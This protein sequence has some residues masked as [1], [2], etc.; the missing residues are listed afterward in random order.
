[1]AKTQS[2]S[3]SSDAQQTESE[4]YLSDVLV[5]IPAYEEE[6]SIG[7]V[8]VAAKNIA[9][10]VVVV[11]DGSTDDTADIAKAAGA[12]VIRHGENKGKGA[13]IRTLFQHAQTEDVDAVVLID[14]DGQ[15]DPED[16]PEVVWPV[17]EGICDVTI[18]SRYMEGDRTETPLY[19]RFG[20]KVLDRLTAS[21]SGTDLSDTQSGF[22]AFS[23]EAIRELAIRTDGMGVESEMIGDAS[24]KDLK[25]SEVPIDVKY[26]DV[27]GQTYNPLR[28]GLS[29]M[30]FVLQLVRDRHPLLFFGVPGVVFLGAGGL[31]GID[32]ILTYQSPRPVSPIFAALTGFVVIVGLLLVF[33]GL[34]LNQVYNMLQTID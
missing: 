12:R 18:G 10:E 27:D 32:V 30:A 24:E 15:H 17:V 29:V 1:M 20:Q 19:R 33:C 3:R 13:A 28:H 25:I 23:P 16:I 11:D 2:V 9:G 5:G 22:R 34:V 7:S 26:D 8:V 14:G 6:T 21:S 31:L 4:G